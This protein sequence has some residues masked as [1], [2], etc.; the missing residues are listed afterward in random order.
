MF[1]G[2]S[3]NGQLGGG[4]ICDKRALPGAVIP[5]EAGIQSVASAFPMPCAVDSRFR[6]ND[7]SAVG[8]RLGSDSK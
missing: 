4:V 7:P 8:F 6:G 3:G 5:A 1:F 2:H